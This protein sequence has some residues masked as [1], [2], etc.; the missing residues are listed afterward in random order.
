[1]STYRSS[2]LTRRVLPKSSYYDSDDEPCRVHRDEDGALTADAYRADKG[3]VK[4]DL[5]DVYYNGIP[6]SQARYDELVHE[7]DESFKR[8]HP[9]VSK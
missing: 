5:T 6:I 2:C 7:R 3:P 8:S 1:V 4:V 9:P